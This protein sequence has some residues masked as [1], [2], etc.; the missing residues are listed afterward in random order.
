MKNN[1][2][3][4]FSPLRQTNVVYKFTC[5]HPHSKAEFYVGMTQ[6]TVFRRL[7]AHTQNG[8]I[9][10]HF[11]NVHNVKPTFKELSENTEILAKAQ[12]RY[13]LSIKEALIIL[14]SLPSLNRQTDNFTNVLKINTRSNYMSVQSKTNNYNTDSSISKENGQTGSPPLLVSRH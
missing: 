10:E 12:N 4:E 13:E 8:S 3:M 1:L 2:S 7:T 9:Y 11:M 14:Q 6:T 5:P